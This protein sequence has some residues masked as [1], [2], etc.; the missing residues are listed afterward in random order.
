VYGEA[1]CIICCQPRVLR[2]LFPVAKGVELKLYEC[3]SCASSMWLITRVSRV[4]AA[5][6]TTIDAALKA[7]NDRSSKTS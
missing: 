3:A 2:A 1:G 5:K 7:A 4:S 6:L